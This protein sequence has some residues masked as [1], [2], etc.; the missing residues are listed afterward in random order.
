MPANERERVPPP[1]L[2]RR[3]PSGRGAM[4]QPNV[5]GDG[6]ARLT[7]RFWGLVVVTGVATGLFGDL[8]ML[9]LFTVEHLAW[10]TPESGNGF[11]AAVAGTGLV[12]RTVPLLIAGVFGGP[13]WYLLRRFTP[14]RKSEVDE[15]LWTGEGRLSFRRSFGTAVISE[16]VVGL[17][18]S[19]GREAAPKLLGGVAGNLL[20]EWGKLSPAQQR[21]L[22]ACGGGAGL[23][24]VYNVPLGGALFTA[25]VLL[26]SIT[27]PTVLPALAC[28]GVA[29][30]TAWLL[31]PQHAT[32]V[33]VPAFTLHPQLVVWAVI[34]GPIVGVLAAAY[35]RLIGWLSHH[36]VTGVPSIFAPLL[37]FA[38]L[39]AL[40][41]AYPQLYGN[42][43]GMAHDAFLGLGSLALLGALSLL[44]PLI[45]AACLGSGASGGLFT[46]VMS[47]G[48]VLGGFLGLVWGQ[49]WSGAPTGAYAMIG[50]TAM[51]GAAMQAPL[52]GLVLVLELTHSGFALM[53]PMI[54]ATAVA[55]AITRWIDG[56]SIYSSRISA[57][58]SGSVPLDPIA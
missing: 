44:K 27:L 14:G 18:A 30:M 22:V 55:T 33:N 32:Y 37:A 3:L 10:G 24:C 39:A 11:T 16:I 41:T 57:A 49:L 6:D 45:T 56:Y 52:S 42:G 53:V 40:G 9:L 47:T 31:L 58:P 43:K 34:I 8:M 13:A 48:A 7:I 2:K 26:G 35:I 15:V 51:I 17:G 19:L 46:P 4:L 1:L 23:A 38:V 36:R 29:T 12:H 5:T 25:E 50:A 28:S 21:F 54:V 20:S